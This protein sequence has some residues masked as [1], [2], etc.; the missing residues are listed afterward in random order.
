MIP[1]TS[2]SV[3]FSDGTADAEDGTVP[4]DA[5]EPAPVVVLLV[6]RLLRNPVYDRPVG[7]VFSS[8]CR[9]VNGSSKHSISGLY[10]LNCR[11]FPRENQMNEL[12]LLGFEFFRW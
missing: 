2:S 4:D 7:A 11:T 1:L 6:K 12:I 3:N 8:V 5:V 9:M 10:N